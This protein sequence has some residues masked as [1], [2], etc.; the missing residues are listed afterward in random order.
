[1]KLDGIVTQRSG[2][3]IT[4]RWNGSDESILGDDDDDLDEFEFADPE[5]IAEPIHVL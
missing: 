4:I 2:D 3:T 5:A 1:M